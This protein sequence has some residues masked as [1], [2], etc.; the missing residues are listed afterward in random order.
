V[1][2]LGS[3]GAGYQPLNFGLSYTGY[4]PQALAS[5]DVDLAVGAFNPAP[6]TVPEPGSLA[7]FSTLFATWGLAGI[8]RRFAARRRSRRGTLRQRVIA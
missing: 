6:G 8:G 5:F 4:D 2:D 1:F 3:L 7:V